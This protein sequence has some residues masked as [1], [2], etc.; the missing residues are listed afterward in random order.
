M[1]FRD[2]L[3]TALAILDRTGIRRIVY[4]PPTHRLLWQLGFEVLPPHFSGRV[5]NFLW[6]WLAFTPPLVLYFALSGRSVGSTMGNGVGF[7]TYFA[8]LAVLLYTRSAQ[9][10]GLP[11]WS[12]VESADQPLRRPSTHWLRD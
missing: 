12:D 1:T 10:Q 6:S 3:N 11:A 7:G 8:L 5:A 9:D 4:A 2:R